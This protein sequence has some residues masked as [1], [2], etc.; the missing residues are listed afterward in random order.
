VTW[1][2]TKT[3]NYGDM[4]TAID[5]NAYWRDNIAYLGD[6]AP[7]VIPTLAAGV[8][9]DLMY[10]KAGGVV[11]MKGGILAPLNTVI[12]TL[13]SGFIPVMPGAGPYMFLVST[14]S[15]PACSLISSGGV[16]TH[17]VEGAA[18]AGNV[19]ASYSAVFFGWV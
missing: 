12:F 4:F 11:Y 10:M 15:A 6:Q 2:G 18:G 16:V 14:E 19:Y 9:R 5:A 3:W 1:H 7:W 8:S 17:L 13:P